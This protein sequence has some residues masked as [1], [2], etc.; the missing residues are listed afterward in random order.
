MSK[1]AISKAW[2]VANAIVD[3]KYKI[4]LMSGRWSIMISEGSLFLF[5]GTAGIDGSICGCLSKDL[6]FSPRGVYT[7]ITYPSS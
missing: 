4:K 1:L 6:L 2:F 7:R 3:Q 5:F